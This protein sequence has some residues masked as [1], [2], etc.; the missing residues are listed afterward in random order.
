M[1]SPE[2][3]KEAGRMLSHLRLLLLARQPFWKMEANTFNIQNAIF[4][5]HIRAD[6]EKE[7]GGATHLVR[8]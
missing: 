6:K 8:F 4:F 7:E 3:D 5:Q 2:K 1:L